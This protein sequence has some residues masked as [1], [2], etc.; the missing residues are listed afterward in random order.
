MLALELMGLLPPGPLSGEALSN[1]RFVLY[2]HCIVMFVVVGL[3]VEV[4]RAS[5]VRKLAKARD[6][7]EAASRAKGGFLAMMSHEIRTP[8]AGLL[9]ALTLAHEE[10][11]E[12]E[13][14][15]RLALATSS[16]ETLRALLDDVLDFSRIEAGRLTLEPIPSTPRAIV[17]EV[18]S[19]FSSAARAKG[20]ELGALF[21]EGSDLGVLV[22]PLRL[23]QVL[24]NLVGNA[25]KFTEVGAIEV[26]VHVSARE[27]DKRLVRFVERDTGAGMTP[28]QL[29]RLFQPFVQ[30][31]ERGGGG[32]TGLGLTISRA[33]M[34]QM[35]G[36][37]ALTSIAGEGTEASVDVAL[38]VARTPEPSVASSAVRDTSELATLRVLV[39]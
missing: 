15:E 12:P 5:S 11:Q 17:R 35:G 32:G 37:L 21:G 26:E 28:S 4:M 27:D 23:R 1:A 14:R 24:S 31:H 38:P 39:A 29:A 13:T 8:L 30:V 9:G 6:A 20:V 10:S 18:V 3:G 36:K 16:A 25:V 19:L 33:I 22:D 7:A 34:E 2:V